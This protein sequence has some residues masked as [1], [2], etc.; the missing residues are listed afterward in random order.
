MSYKNM[1]AQ[2]VVSISEVFKHFRDYIC[3]RN[4]SYDYSTTGI[5]WTLIDSSYAT[6][7]DT[8]VSG[9]YFVVYSSGESGTEQM[10]Y[11][12]VMNGTAYI[13]VYGYLYWDNVVHTG[14]QE[15]GVA[16]SWGI[17]ITCNSLYIYGDLDNITSILDNTGLG[18]STAAMYFGKYQSPLDGPPQTI[19]GSLTA[20]TDVPI[21]V[22]DSSAPLLEAGRY[23]FIYDNSNV[24]RILIKTNNGTTT[25]TADLANSYAAGATLRSLVPYQA[26]GD[27]SDFL[28]TTAT[29]TRELITLTGNKNSGDAKIQVGNIPNANYVGP[30]IQTHYLSSPLI[31]VNSSAGH[32]AVF[33]YPHILSAITVT[34][35]SYL[36]VLD[37]LVSGNAYRRLLASD[38]QIFIKEV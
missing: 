19:S 17:L 8:P 34:G 4:G 38:R 26:P 35:I 30:G 29:D 10:Y 3:A 23:A 31:L 12:I 6:D 14:T 1:V 32:N 36:D 13:S 27:Y 2:P 11:K 7:E 5:G 18:S 9:D 37:D 20:G 25:I 16:N 22:A 28:D 24:E 15:Y 21:V 33:I